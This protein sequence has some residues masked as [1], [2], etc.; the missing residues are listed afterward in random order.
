M[1]H[2]SHYWM[3]KV[4]MR[5]EGIFGHTWR[6]DKYLCDVCEKEYD[7]DPGICT[8]EQIDNKYKIVCK[9]CKHASIALS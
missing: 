6:K 3:K 1:V 5:V 8:V 4:P 9:E 7:P 2:G